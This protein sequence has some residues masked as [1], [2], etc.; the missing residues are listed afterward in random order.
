MVSSTS[1]SC[2]PGIKFHNGD[3]LTA[4]DVKFSFDRLRAKDSGYSYGAQVEIIA[5]VDVVDPLTVSFKLSK[6]TGPVPHLHGV[7]RQLDRAEEAGR[8]RP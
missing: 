4:E 7:S 2:A 5:S 1:S 3:E 8:V 6:R